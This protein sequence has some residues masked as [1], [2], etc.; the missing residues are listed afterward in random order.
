MRAT[1]NTLLLLLL[2]TC[3]YYYCF[4]DYYYLLAPYLLGRLPPGAVMP[5]FRYRMPPS[6]P[7]RPTAYPR[8][9]PTHEPIPN[10]DGQVYRPPQ[11]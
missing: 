4:F 5:C 7:G 6:L 3:Y 10:A 11:Q 2:L 9:P 8:G 1:S